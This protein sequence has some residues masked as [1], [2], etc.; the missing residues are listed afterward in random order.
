MALAWFDSWID[1]HKRKHPHE[2]WKRY[3][4]ANFTA[5]R[6]AFEA[7]AVTVEEALAASERLMTAPPG[8]PEHHL[9]ALLETILTHRTTTRI[10]QDQRRRAVEMARRAADI[11]RT[12]EA[13]ALWKDLD[14]ADRAATLDRLAE[15][16]PG[17]ATQPRWLETLAILTIAESLEAQATT[18]A[19][20]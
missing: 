14:P 3:D 17:M 19:G 8:W 11:R 13:R 4:T 12:A 15:Q 2:G 5:W 16:N 7:R 18:L 1:H 9:A 10:E 20:A 6:R